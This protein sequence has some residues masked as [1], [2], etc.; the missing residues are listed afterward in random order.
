MQATATTRTP[1]VRAKAPLARASF[2][3]WE[4]EAPYL[5]QP[6]HSCL[7][8]IS[9]DDDSPYMHIWNWFWEHS[10]DECA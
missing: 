4:R 1:R 5:I 10:D 6:D 8:D 7:A 9:D 3:G 2:P